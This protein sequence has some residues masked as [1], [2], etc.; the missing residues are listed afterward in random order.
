MR[1]R[2]RPAHLRWCSWA[3]PVAPRDRGRGRLTTHPSDWAIT[4]LRSRSSL[5]FALY[6]RS[7]SIGHCRQRVASPA[8]VDFALLWKYCSEPNDDTRVGAAGANQW[9]C[10]CVPVSGACGRQR[11][12]DGRTGSSWSWARSCS[13]PPGPSARKR[14]SARSASARRARCAPRSRVSRARRSARCP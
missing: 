12:R 6:G 4:A 1:V 7:P 2:R 10:R 13:W 11:R 14:T 3:S 5:F 9:Q 8:A